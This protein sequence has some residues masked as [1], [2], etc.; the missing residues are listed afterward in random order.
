[1]HA[2]FEIRGRASS[3]TLWALVFNDY[4]FVAG[5]EVKIAWRMTGVGPLSLA[6][7]NLATRQK[8]VPLR[9]AEP[10]ISSTWHRPGDE[11]G[12]VWVFPAQGCW[13]LTAVR[14]IGN[15]SITVTV[16]QPPQ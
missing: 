3:A 13:R 15:G 16:T 5:Q 14:S 7:T 10:H 9:G 6:A 2:L 11:W 12:S 1:V 8:A 4:P